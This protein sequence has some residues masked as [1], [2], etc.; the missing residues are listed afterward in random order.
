MCKTMFR[1]ASAVLRAPCD[2]YAFMHF[3]Y[4]MRAGREIMGTL[5]TQ[6]WLGGGT[7]ALDNAAYLLIISIPAL[8]PCLCW[9]AALW[10]T[11]DG[12]GMG[13]NGGGGGYGCRGNYGSGS[14]MMGDWEREGRRFGTVKTVPY[15]LRM[16][17]VGRGSAGECRGKILRCAQNDMP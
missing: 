2:A 8:P 13:N 9:Y 7:G 4:I 15:C 10:V 6:A 16:R 17:D 12:A 1:R 5:G 14:A 3:L 11:W